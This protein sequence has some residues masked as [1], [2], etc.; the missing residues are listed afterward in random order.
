MVTAAALLLGACGDDMYDNS[1]NEP[2]KLSIDS[3]TVDLR[4]QTVT[5][6][7]TARDASWTVTGNPGWCIISPA[8]GDVGISQV[9]VALTS[10]DPEEIEGASMRQATLTFTS[11]GS[12]KTVEI[13]QLNTE[14]TLPNEH[15]DKTINQAIHEELKDWYYNGEPRSVRADFNQSYYDFYNNYL[16][17]LS[18]N[19]FDGNVWATGNE[20]FL[21]SYIEKNHA[22]TSSS[23]I[24]PLNYGMEFDLHEFDGKLV[25]R[26]L[27]VVERSPAARAGLRRG[28]WFYKVNG[29]QLGNWIETATGKYQYNRLID[30][31]V[32][33]VAG[34]N[35]ELG[36][37]A[38][39]PSLALVDEGRTIAVQPE[40]FANNPILHTQVIEE[41][42]LAVLGGDMT[43]TGY[44]MYNS[45]DPAYQTQL[46]ATFRDVF[47]NRPEGEELDNFILDLRYNK[48]GSVETAE[49]L[50]NLL[51]G[52]VPG[53]AG[54]TFAEYRFDRDNTLAQTRTARFESHSSGIGVD[55]VFVLTSPYTAGASELL[56]NALRGLDQQTEVKLVVIGAVTQGLA[57]GMVKR[58]YRPGN[59]W[60]YSAWMLA[61]RP[62]NDAR[63]GDYMYGL[64]PNGGEVDEWDRSNN[65]ANIKWSGTWGW[66]GIP[67]SEDKLLERAV[68]MIKGSQNIPLGAVVNSAQRQRKDLPREF[69]FPTNM[70]IM[71]DN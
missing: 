9:T 12:E 54:K 48:N 57:A 32:H 45:F 31:L 18:L 8:S 5:I 33:P 3:I 27:Y 6:G 65:G 41:S 17:N 69:C 47:K 62:Y 21:Y 46:V 50:G 42:R 43:Y 64:V 55:T 51:V 68:Q 61:C 63:Q 53:V 19:T 40:N 39:R 24:P 10:N 35:P 25:G 22:G 7:V 34:E 59:E 20:R 52:D 14:I 70:M 66:K 38:L 13:R 30:S 2:L 37:L 44:M 26:I 28:D 16:E 1:P 15:A 60:E 58:T 11:D 23:T 4:A 67:G 36:M 71:V 49:L 56:I 29:H